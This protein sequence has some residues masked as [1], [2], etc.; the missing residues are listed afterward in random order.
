[1]PFSFNV[2]DWKGTAQHIADLWTLKKGRHRAICS[3]WN[4]PTRRAELRCTV[5]GDLAQSHAD[6]DGLHLIDLAQTWKDQF[7]SKGWTAS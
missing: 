2:P 7:L 6:H 4:H 1:M 5:D 3:L